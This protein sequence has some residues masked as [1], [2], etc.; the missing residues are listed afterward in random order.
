MGLLADHQ[1]RKEV[2]ITPFTD[3]GERPGVISYGLSSY[4]YDARVGRDYKIFTNVNNT[5]VDVKNFDPKSFVDVKDVDYCI[6]PPNSFALAKTFERFEIPRS[7]LA[8]CLGK[9]SYARAGVV[10]NVTPIEPCWFGTITVEISNTTP[11]P[12]KIYSMEGILQLLFFRGDSVCERSYA[13]K[14]GRY[15]NQ[16]DITL[17]FVK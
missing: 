4:G 2:K 6:I 3:Y 16:V 15:Q 8:V 10:V 7:M 1:I 11:L 14:S 12:C 17:P 13:D 5:L 9:S